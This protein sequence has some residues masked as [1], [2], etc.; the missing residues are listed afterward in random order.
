MKPTSS[1]ARA[2]SFEYFELFDEMFGKDPNVTP[3]YI[4]SSTRGRNN[5]HLHNTGEDDNEKENDEKMQDKKSA[6]IKQKPL[7]QQ[8]TTFNE[9]SKSK[10][11][12]KERRHQEQDLRRRFEMD[13]EEVYD[14]DTVMLE[15]TLDNILAESSLSSTSL[16][17]DDLDN[18]VLDLENTSDEEDRECDLYMKSKPGEAITVYKIA[19]LFQKAYSIIATV[20]KEI[21]EFASTGIYPINPNVFSDEV[22]PLENTVNENLGEE[23][24]NVE[25][26]NNK[27]SEDDQKQ[28]NNVQRKTVTFAEMSPAPRL[29]TS[30]STARKQH[31]KVLTAT[32]ENIILEEKENKRLQR[33]AGGTK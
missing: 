26:I 8:L 2:I 4:A 9:N 20:A 32:P 6:K 29:S 15:E 30:K 10:E 14:A 22:F 16:V 12:S 21:S 7:L 13:A 19:E 17:V 23:L 28:N 5:M 24:N 18:L 27:L 3:K 33:I 1:G 11:E 25:A 31:S